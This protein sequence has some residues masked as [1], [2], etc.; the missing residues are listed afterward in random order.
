MEKHE[1]VEMVHLYDEAIRN[2]GLLL[3]ELVEIKFSPR[4]RNWLGQCE[5]RERRDEKYCILK[6][7]TA[8]LTLPKEAVR[9]IVVHEILHML[10]GSHGHDALW[11]EG[12]KLVH[13]WW[14]EINITQVAPRDV[15][16]AFCKALPKRKVYK[17]S[18]PACDCNTKVFKKTGVVRAIE[19]GEL[20]CPYCGGEL[21][22]E[23][24]REQW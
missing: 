11:R 17:I 4:A 18:C 23:E 7:A 19:R 8:L 15:S 6:F 13:H 16:M 5:S 24:G 2:K 14:P 20:R 12:G 3:G 1:V 22:V 10:R 9:N 21:T